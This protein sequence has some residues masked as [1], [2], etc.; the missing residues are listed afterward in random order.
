MILASLTMALLCNAM[1]APAAVLAFPGD[2]EIE[3][4]S[5]KPQYR[6]GERVPVRVRDTDTNTFVSFDLLTFTFTSN[7]ERPGGANWGHVEADPNDPTQGTLIV[8]DATIDPIFGGSF[9]LSVE[10]RVKKVGTGTGEVNPALSVRPKDVLIK[11]QVLSSVLGD[12]PLDLRQYPVTWEVEPGACSVEDVRGEPWLWVPADLVGSQVSV[13]AVFAGGKARTPALLLCPQ[14]WCDG[15]PPPATAPSGNWVSL[16]VDQIAAPFRYEN[17]AQGGSGGTV[18]DNTL[19][20][21]EAWAILLNGDAV[22]LRG[23]RN[24]KISVIGVERPAREWAEDG[25]ES[26]ALT[27]CNG[28][29]EG[30]AYVLT[31]EGTLSVDATRME[32]RTGSRMSRSPVRRVTNY[33]GGMTL[34]EVT[35]GV[36]SGTYTIEE[37]NTNGSWNPARDPSTRPIRFTVVK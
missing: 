24:S 23:E 27:M 34:Q 32:G 13:T 14:Y 7:P 12:Q 18:R 35:P 22:A 3:Y 2:L 20:H 25:R 33:R 28:R 15:G 26:F 37:V 1:P 19:E 30:A 6:N 9:S 4:P 31:W 5:G 36:W 11:L 17:R 29:R 8:D 16:R 10:Y 21:E